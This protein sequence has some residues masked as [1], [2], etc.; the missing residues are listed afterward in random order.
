MT[1]RKTRSATAAAIGLCVALA[2][3]GCAGGS[4]LDDGAGSSDGKV[5]LTFWGNATTGAGKQFW[6][7]AAKAY[8]AEHPNVT[9]KIQTIQN[10]DF[11]GK[12]Q[13]ALNSSSAPDIFLQRGGGKMQAMAEAGQIKALEL[14]DTDRTN[15][16]EAAIAGVSIGGKTYAMP[17]DTQPEG[18]YYS[19]DLFK[20]AGI[21]SPPK[22]MD[23]LE[24]AVTKL[25]AIDVAPIAVGAK[26]A[27]PAAHW[28]YNFAVRECSQDVMEAAAQS[29][30]FD[31]ACWTEAGEDLAAFLETEPF[32]KG[33]LTASAQQGAG[34]SAGMLANHKAAMELM[35]NWNPGVIA[36][37]TPDEKPLPDLG[38][39]PFPAVDGGKGDPTAIMGG[40]GGYSVSK[41]APKEALGFLQFVVTKEQQEAYAEAFETI[42]VNKAAQGVV[43]DSYNISA[44]DAFNKAAYSMQFLDTQYGQ[45]VG[46]AMNVAVVNLMAGKGTA[47]DIVKDVNAAAEKG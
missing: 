42:P 43:T 38:W 1:T 6:E 31:D 34:S 4:D 30:E 25:K 9:I 2:A 11:D 20:K 27:W 39:F 35:G 13:T 33:Y 21:A 3:T 17:V 16:G 36:G 47:A 12:L 7:D 19:K 24:A 10:E 32:Q 41:N 44:L 45:N 22:T 8:E 37:L 28:Y 29:L 18:I 40:A 14:T 5:G 23:E 26:D 46:N 15:V